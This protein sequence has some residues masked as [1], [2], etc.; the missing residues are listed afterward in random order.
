MTL[1]MHVLYPLL[2]EG[3][4]DQNLSFSSPWTNPSLPCLPI[5]YI[6]HSPVHYYCHIFLIDFFV[7]EEHT[8]LRILF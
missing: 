2:I 7:N 3:G 4:G 6:I 1:I 8:L 5:Q